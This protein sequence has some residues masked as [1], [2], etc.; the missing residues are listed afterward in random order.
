MITWVFRFNNFLHRKK[1]PPQPY[2]LFV[3][4]EIKILNKF[5][6]L[7]SRYE[8]GLECS[9]EHWLLSL[10]GEHLSLNLILC[11]A[12]D[13]RLAIRILLDQSLLNPIVNEL[14]GSLV[15]LCCLVQLVQLSLE[16]LDMLTLIFDLGGIGL[17][18][19]LM[20]V[21]ESEL[22]L[23]VNL[24]ATPFA[25]RFQNMDTPSLGGFFYNAEN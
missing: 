17:A 1:L 19:C 3:W 23:H 13:I 6:E 4:W 7:T 10:A 2:C 18:I 22:G 9:V 8:Q 16:N 25:T 11:V 5:A 21:V 12:D 15:S 20:N 24:G 14:G